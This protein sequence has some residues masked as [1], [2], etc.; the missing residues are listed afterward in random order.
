MILIQTNQRAGLVSAKLSTMTE[1]ANWPLSKSN[2]IR[3]ALL[4]FLE[5]EKQADI[6]AYLKRKST[7]RR[8]D[9]QRG[10]R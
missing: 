7:P 2:S 6:G 8:L 3:Y 5:G 9:S 4:H 1:T 10:F